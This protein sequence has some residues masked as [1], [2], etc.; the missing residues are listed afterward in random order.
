MTYNPHNTQLLH[1]FAKKQMSTLV[2]GKINYLIVVF[3]HPCLYP[4]AAWQITTR[5]D[6]QSS[7][8][9][10]VLCSKYSNHLNP[11]HSKSLALD[12]IGFT[13]TS[14]ERC[15]WNCKICVLWTSLI[16]VLWIKKTVTIWIPGITGIQIV[17]VVLKVLL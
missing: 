7:L 16:R 14:M 2:G 9:K 17:T 15:K 6:P 12:Y 8:Y 13:L 10:T 1:D 11:G 4:C 3:C 5:F